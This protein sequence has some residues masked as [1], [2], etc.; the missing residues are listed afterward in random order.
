MLRWKNPLRKS[1]HEALFTARVGHHDRRCFGPGF[2]AAPC[3]SA[4]RRDEQRIGGFCANGGTAWRAFV[5]P[6]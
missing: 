2:V 1:I 4:V 5:D 6:N 3:H